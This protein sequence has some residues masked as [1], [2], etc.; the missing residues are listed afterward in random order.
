MDVVEFIAQERDRFKR[1]QAI[2]E[3]LK[4]IERKL[5]IMDGFNL[6]NLNFGIKVFPSPP[7][8]VRVKN[9][10]IGI[11]HDDRAKLEGLLYKA[12]MEGKTDGAR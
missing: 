10:Y 2:D 3:E 8:A 12:M 9:Y 5:T 1:M 7:D 4:E 11:L 6:Q